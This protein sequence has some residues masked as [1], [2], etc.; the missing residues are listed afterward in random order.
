MFE[1]QEPTTYGQIAAEAKALAASLQKMGLVEGDVISFQLPNWREAVAINIAA[2]ALG[3]VVNPISPIYRGSELRFI[4]QDA[5]T[6]IAFIPGEYRGMNYLRLYDFLLPEL[7]EL[8]KVITVG[9]EGGDE[10]SYA[11]IL[12]TK[13]A[14]A[15]FPSIDPNRVKMVMY[16][17][18]T[19]GNAKGVLHTHRSIN[20]THQ[21]YKKIWGIKSD[22]VMYMPSPITHGTGYILGIELP[23]FTDAPTVFMDRWD[24]NKAIDV[25][26]ETKATFC[27]G[28]T[29]FLK[30]LI[31]EA[32]RRQNRLPS[33]RFFSCGG[34]AVPSEIIYEANR[35][36]ER[37]RASRVYGSTEA[38]L[39]TKGCVAPN[40]LSAAAETD[41][42]IADFVV[43]V[44][45]KNGKALGFD[46]VGEI[47]VKGSPLMVGYTNED[48]NKIAFDGEGYFRTGD[49]GYVNEAGCLTITGRRKDLI[50]RGGENLSPKE[51]EEHLERHP[52]VQEAA[53]VA[54]PHPRLG[55]TACA[56]IVV[57]GGF[58]APSLTELAA[59][60]DEEG[61]ARQKFPE[62]L[63][64]V[65]AFPRTPSGKV[66]KDILRDAVRQPIKL[67]LVR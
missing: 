63:E 17:S 60:L 67:Q 39:V 30:D 34:A 40:D 28:A 22:D 48:E 21:S 24:P 58:E 50:I 35:Y 8:R 46:K 42:R 6:K 25:I 11:N 20:E 31:E 41:G 10:N 49:L 32:K 66:R 4:L 2:A 55:E 59:F 57:A 54:M 51:I 3:L 7:P 43:K 26:N 45:D 27:A 18:G 56:F 37:C 62:R 14:A 61:L 36:T 53:V 38:P 13:G 5:K 44:I 33:L 12:R 52:A 9:D 47:L 64:Y 65:D 23:F 29:V 15:K 16:T 1:G 19:T